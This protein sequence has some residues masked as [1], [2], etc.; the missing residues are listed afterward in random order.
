MSTRGSC[1]AV[2]VVVVLVVT[3]S[4]KTIMFS[5]EKFLLHI[6]HYL[7]NDFNENPRR[8]VI[9]RLFRERGGL[10]ALPG[11][12]IGRSLLFL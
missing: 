10:E 6:N 3:E 9:S 12:A 7:K 4:A 2:L 8:F 1:R 5:Y 11:G